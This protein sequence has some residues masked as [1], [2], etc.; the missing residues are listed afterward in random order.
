[1]KTYVITW[2]VVVKRPDGTQATLVNKMEIMAPG[3]LSATEKAI[4]YVEELKGDLMKIE[5]KVGESG[6]DF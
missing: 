6:E 5:V 4:D 3:F 2:T 1:M